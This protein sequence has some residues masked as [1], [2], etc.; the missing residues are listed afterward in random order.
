MSDA[1]PAYAEHFGSRDDEGVF[2]RTAAPRHLA[3]HIMS[4]S[5]SPRIES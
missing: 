3:D 1:S 4:V 2:A 5:P